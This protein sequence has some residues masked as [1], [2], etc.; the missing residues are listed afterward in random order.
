[1]WKNLTRMQIVLM[2]IVCFFFSF[3]VY[4]Q[5]AI[6]ARSAFGNPPR[7]WLRARRVKELSDYM[8]MCGVLL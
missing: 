7:R 2:R 5:S 4:Q 1:M 8:H 3:I 6:Q